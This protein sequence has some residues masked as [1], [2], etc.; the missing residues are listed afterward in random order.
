MN[1]KIGKIAASLL[2]TLAAALCSLAVSAT[3]REQGMEPDGTIGSGQ[4]IGL[5]GVQIPFPFSDH[6]ACINLGSVPGLPTAYGG[7]TFKYDDPNTVL[8]GGGA[9]DSTGRIYQIAVTRDVNRHITGFSGTTTIYPRS[10][11]RIGQYNDGG[12]AF[13]PGNVLFVARYPNNQVEQSKPGSTG[14]NKVVDLASLGVT[15]SVGSLA[16]VPQGFPGAG[17]MKLVSFPSGDWYHA[18]Y[19]PDG[20]GTFN[21]NSATLRTNIGGA[22][23]IA[24]VPPGS[25][26]FASTSSALIA[27]YS[28][29]TIIATPLDANGD[30]I[31]AQSQPFMTGI[32]GPEGTAVDP[33][34]GDLFISTSGTGDKIVRVSGFAVPPAA[35]IPTPPLCGF[36]VGIVYASPSGVPANQLWDEISADLDVASMGM[37]S[38]GILTP[39]LA[40]L[41]QYDVVVV[42]SAGQFGNPTT[43]GDNLADY[44]DGGGVVIE[45]AYGYY[46]P[47]SVMGL[48]GRWLTGNYSP[49]NYST[50]ERTGGFAGSID[51]PAHRHPLMAGITTLQFNSMLAGSL[52]PGATKVATAPSTEAGEAL[53]DYRTV[54]GGHTVVGIA[55]YLGTDTH[56]GD[57]GKVIANAAR[58]LR[59]CRGLTPAPTPAPTATP[60]ATATATPTAT[61]T[62]APTATVTP[63]PTATATPTAIAS[64][65]PSASPTATPSLNSHLVNISTRLRVESGDNVLIAGFIIDG[66]APKRIIVRGIGPSLAA[67]G[68]TDS[69]QDP[70]L[71]LNVNGALLATND[72]WSDNPNA[73]EIA[74][75]GLAP[76]NQMESALF[77]AVAPGSYTAVLRGKGGSTGVGLV[78]V[79]DLDANID[80]KVINIS[81]RGFV[82]AGENVMIAGLIVTGDAPSQLVVRALGPSLGAFGVPNPLADP[83][84]EIHNGNGATIQTNNNWRDNQEG[85]L[86]ATGLAPGND[87]E[88][89][90]LISVMPGNYTAT[91]R[92]A[93]GGIGNGLVEVYKLSP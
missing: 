14:V 79:Y 60:T 27:K 41:R 54:S 48:S 73:A 43:F 46:G 78:E 56:S 53:V 28:S 30:P 47:A 1:G 83:F 24:F 12:V 91:V 76:Q 9:N 31:V 6:Y 59:P 39:T 32:T 64:A 17:S 22:E 7:L 58:W 3:P 15:T 4:C 16:F 44:V 85:A 68:I 18:D 65:T 71:E 89:A 13:G 2:L 84:L 93:D 40:Q 51:D 81:T 49:F 82:R 38:A 8:I 63:A 50:V 80:S 75:T 88:S 23:G 35:P 36:R 5:P 42:V 37:L 92:G 52:P 62:V 26:A 70:T 86:R 10:T 72:N 90:I 25:P 66:T 77:T 21:I 45:A 29:N 67:F 87:S 33:V 57:W 61:A 11:S 19:S 69:L 20:N 55:A 34:T 74:S